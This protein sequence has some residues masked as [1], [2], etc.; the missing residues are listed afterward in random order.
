[1]PRRAVQSLAL[2]LAI[3]LG[4][5]LAV[6]SSRPYAL[7]LSYGVLNGPGEGLGNA[8]DRRVRDVDSA[9]TRAL[10]LSWSFAEHWRFHGNYART[11]ARYA[12]TASV[13]CP[14]TGGLL[15]P[16]FG[17]LCLDLDDRPPGTFVDR[18]E[19]GGLSIS[20]F[21]S[22]GDSVTLEA[23]LGAQHSRWRA[24]D[25]IEARL[26][27][28]CETV[29][30]LRGVPDRA[31]AVPGCTAVDAVASETFP[32]AAVR[33][34]VREGAGWSAT[35][36]V[37][38]QGDRHRIYRSDVLDRALRANCAD[39]G[40]CRLAEVRTERY[41]ARIPR[42]SWVWYSLRLG[43]WVSD[44]VEVFGEWVG[45]GTRDWD[46]GQVGVVLHF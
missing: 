6:A 4:A 12:T 18:I 27:A 11:N 2:A 1:M 38:F 15:N 13:G 29:D 17:N 45:G 30:D 40:F 32:R 26:V 21:W 20:R 28:T 3:I 37:Q 5:P 42:S 43:K 7:E 19:E 39:P 24:A 31:F 33:V 14:L 16:L 34:Q 8:Q 23:E 10:R 46:G 9:R 25:D 35:A 44:E 22:I 41:A 36:A